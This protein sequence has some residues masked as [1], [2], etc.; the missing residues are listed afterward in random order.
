[1]IERKESAHFELLLREFRELRRRS[2]H[3]G[4]SGTRYLLTMHLNRPKLRLDV[5]AEILPGRFCTQKLPVVADR[6]AIEVKRLP[7]LEPH[8]QAEAIVADAFED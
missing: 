2:G 8:A 5:F 7:A 3:S 4:T 1:M 6:R